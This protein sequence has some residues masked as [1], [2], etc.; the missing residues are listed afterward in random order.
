MSAGSLDLTIW[1]SKLTH[2]ADRLGST[3]AS[4]KLKGI[5]GEAHN[6]G[7]MWFNSIRSERPY[8][9]LTCYRLVDWKQTMIRQK[10]MVTQVLHGCLQLV[11]WGVGLSAETSATPIACSIVIRDC[12]DFV[13]EE[14]G[15]GGKSARPLCLGPHTP[16][17][18][19]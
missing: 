1:G 3:A 14:G 10:W 7:S 6:Q 16:Y 11:P 12:P 18:G 15:D 9:D 4:L 8:P 13:G 5:D 2:E 19:K 17:N